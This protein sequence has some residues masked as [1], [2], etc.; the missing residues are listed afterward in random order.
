VHTLDL[1][2]VVELQRLVGSRLD[3]QRAAAEQPLPEAVPELHAVD[4]GHRDVDAGAGQ[5]TLTHQHPL[6]SHHEVRGA[7]ADQRDHGEPDDHYRADDADRN[8]GREMPVL[9][10]DQR[11]EE[12]PDGDG[13]QE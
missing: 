4:P 9:V 10:A 3:D 6:G 8:P 5:H 2:D 11:R 13:D 1:R 7:P 12:Y